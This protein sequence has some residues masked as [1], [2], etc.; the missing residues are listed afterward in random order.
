VFADELDCVCVVVDCCWW[1]VSF[2]GRYYAS[3]EAVMGTF[4]NVFSW[5]SKC[6]L[7]G[8]RTPAQV[9]YFLEHSVFCSSILY[10]QLLTARSSS[11]GAPLVGVAGEP[12]GPMD[13][14]AGS[15]MSGSDSEGDADD[16]V[17]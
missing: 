1:C 15:D 12:V 5:L 10:N 11:A 6:I 17:L 9:K 3:G 16:D 4:R 7:G 14:Q 8:S 2:C 13:D